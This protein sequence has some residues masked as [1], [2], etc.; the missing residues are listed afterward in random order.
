MIDKILNASFNLQLLDSNFS[1]WEYRGINKGDSLV[2]LRGLNLTDGL[3]SDDAQLAS[4]YAAAAAA[5]HAAGTIDWKIHNE[6][7]NKAKLEFEQT[8]KI[9]GFEVLNLRTF[10]KLWISNYDLETLNK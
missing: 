10:D 5:G 6:I 9:K 2:F 3:A 8:G 4:S 7:F 1:I